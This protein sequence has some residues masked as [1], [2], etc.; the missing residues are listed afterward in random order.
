[1]E[2]KSPAGMPMGGPGMRTGT[3]LMKLLR[4][5]CEKNGVEIL[6]NTRV[7]DAEVEHGKFRAILAKALMVR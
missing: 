7:T 5:T 1:M 3:Y 4:E 6:L 2:R